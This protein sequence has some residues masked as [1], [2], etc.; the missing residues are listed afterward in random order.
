M[1]I[2]GIIATIL[3]IVGAATFAGFL[4]YALV[5]LSENEGFELDDTDYQEDPHHE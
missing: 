5:K 3:I 1:L 4:F 2:F